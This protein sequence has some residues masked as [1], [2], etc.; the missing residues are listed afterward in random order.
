[1]LKY[2]VG[3]LIDAARSGEVNVIGHGCNCFTTMGSGIAPQIAKAWPR[4]LRA[5]QET[6]KGDRNK[7][8]N[9]TCVTSIAEDLMIF[10]LYTQYGFWGR[11]KGLRDLDYNA[12]YDALRRMRTAIINGPFIDVKVGLPL[13]GCGLAGGNWRIV[14]RIIEE[15][16]KDFDIT[17]YV[18]S[19]KDIPQND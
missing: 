9:Y 6:V 13:I 16:F 7:L 14:S 2:K 11:N 18:L 4:V 15:V 19:E 8:G 5:D 1:M 17:I 10:N 3:N 12:L